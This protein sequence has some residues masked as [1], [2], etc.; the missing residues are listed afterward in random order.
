MT[1]LFGKGAEP[2]VSSGRRTNETWSLLGCEDTSEVKFNRPV[3]HL[4]TICGKAQSA[5]GLPRTQ[6]CFQASWD[7]VE[8][9]PTS[10]VTTQYFKAGTTG[11]RP[12]N[13][14][15]VGQVAPAGGQE[16]AECGLR[17]PNLT[18]EKNTALASE[19]LP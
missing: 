11:L 2:A 5:P 12:P 3:W 1:R 4:G 14:K 18:R 16:P 10:I 17:T 19:P 13:F 9:L 15:V 6:S 8:S 7:S